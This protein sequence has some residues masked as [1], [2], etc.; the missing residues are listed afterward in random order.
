MPLP[1]V[2]AP[3]TPME[4]GVSIDD[5]CKE[6]TDLSIMPRGTR[7][8]RRHRE[9]DTPNP[10]GDRSARSPGRQGLQPGIR[11]AVTSPVTVGQ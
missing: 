9:P 11:V 10:P 1:I 2:P 7:G 5:L 4:E 8:R 3:M 6:R